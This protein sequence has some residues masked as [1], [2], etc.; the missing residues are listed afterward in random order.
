MNLVAN[1]PTP[2]LFGKHPPAPT[3]KTKPSR[4]TRG[5]RWRV[6]RAKPGSG[7]PPGGGGAGLSR[8]KIEGDCRG[9]LGLG[10]R[11]RQW[12]LLVGAPVAAG[13]LAL[14]PSSLSELPLP[15]EGEHSTQQHSQHITQHHHRR[16]ISRTRHHGAPGRAP[17]SRNPHACEFHKTTHNGR[18]HRARTAPF[19]P[20][21]L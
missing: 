21:R 12:G 10:R 6:R 20:Q 9:G 11:E 19:E 3:R 5:A 16:I 7:S 18:A 8:P 1:P 14:G 2:C 13:R 4:P 17:Q 15:A